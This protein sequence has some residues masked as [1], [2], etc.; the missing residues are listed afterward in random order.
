MRASSIIERRVRA[1][2]DELIPQESLTKRWL[3]YL[4]ATPAD[5]VTPE[6][7]AEPFDEIVW[8]Q[9]PARSRD[10]R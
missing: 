5:R 2:E 3:L 6:T 9:S 7:K 10:R 1:L 8:T 4:V